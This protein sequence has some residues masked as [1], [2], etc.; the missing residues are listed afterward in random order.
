MLFL[1]CSYKG[2]LVAQWY[3]T[4][5]FEDIADFYVHIRDSGNQLLAERRLSYLER[6]VQIPGDEIS[7][8]YDGQLELCVL[9]KRSDGDIR[10]WF[11]TQCIYLP[12]NLETIKQT[13]GA[14]RNQPYMIHSLRK[15]IR[16]PIADGHS[17]STK[18]RQSIR[19]AGYGSNAPDNIMIYSAILLALHAFF[20]LLE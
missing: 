19:S 9:A 17:K 15:R 20:S 6:A 12:E 11:E 10:T 8:N 18:R 16:A 13:Y 7:D 5:L 3:V 2:Q 14:L 4:A 1:F